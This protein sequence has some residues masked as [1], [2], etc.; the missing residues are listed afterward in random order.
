MPTWIILVHKHKYDD[1]AVQ[2]V[3]NAFLKNKPKF[4]G[5]LSFYSSLNVRIDLWKIGR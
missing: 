4:K 2:M 3:Y 1:V 5:T